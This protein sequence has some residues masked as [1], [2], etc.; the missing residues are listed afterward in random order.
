M[1]HYA[2]TEGTTTFTDDQGHSHLA[3]PTDRARSAEE[4]GRIRYILLIS[5]ALAVV[6]LS[7]A[8]VGFALWA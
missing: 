5:T 6:L 7:L 4:T 2:E 3:V 1:A 8:V